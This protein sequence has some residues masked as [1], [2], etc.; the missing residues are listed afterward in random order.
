M[1]ESFS[2]QSSAASGATASLVPTRASSRQASAFVFLGRVRFE[3]GDQLG[4]LALGEGLGSLSE[5]PAATPATSTRRGTARP[6][7]VVLNMRGF[8]FPRLTLC[9]ID[10][11]FP[12]GAGAQAVGLG[13]VDEL[14]LDGVVFHVALEPHADVG[15]MDGAH[16]AVHD[17]GVGHGLAA[18]T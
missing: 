4:F 15:G 14:L 12:L 1:C 9:Q 7:I 16:G 3:D 11:G 13:V 6:T 5:R 17:L 18:A 2:S 8:S 10:P